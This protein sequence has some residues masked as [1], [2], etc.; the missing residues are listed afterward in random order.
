MAFGD[1]AHRRG[2]ATVDILGVIAL[3]LVMMAL[4]VSAVRTYS[5]RSEISR[6]LLAVAPVQ[7]L[8]SYS[9][10]RTGVPPASEDDVPGLNDAIA[11]YRVVETIEVEHGRI[12]IRYDHDAV[13]SLRGKTLYLTP[14]ETTDG[15]VVWICG[16]GAADVG[17]Y[18]LGFSG[19]TNRPTELV[20]MV[21]PRYLPSGC[22]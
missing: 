7:A 9:F 16:D 18:P 20:A 15:R 21:E 1:P 4:A 22:R 3:T 6:T 10:E 8:I 17:L 19:G 12:A 2:I 13:T 11:G 5:A 14:F